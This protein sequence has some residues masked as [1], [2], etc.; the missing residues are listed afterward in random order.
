MENNMPNMTYC[1][2]QNVLEDYEQAYEHL[3]DVGIDGLSKIE[4]EKVLELIRLSK[5]FVDEFDVV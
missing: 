3:K 4:R 5:D 1:M 2:F